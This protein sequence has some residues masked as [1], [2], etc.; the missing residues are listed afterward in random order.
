MRRRGGRLRLLFR[1]L[2]LEIL[3]SIFPLILVLLEGEGGTYGFDTA[4]DEIPCAHT[5]PST[6][7]N[8]PSSSG[9]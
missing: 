8:C 5:T 2:C 4:V 3:I 9:E 1:I 6:S 7:F